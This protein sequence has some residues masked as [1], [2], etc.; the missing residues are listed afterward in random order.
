MPSI[1]LP[2]KLDQQTLEASLAKLEKTVKDNGKVLENSSLNFSD[3][4]QKGTNGFKNIVVGGAKAATIAFGTIAAT[5]A[6]VAAVS[7]GL[8]KTFD[9]VQNQVDTLGRAKLFGATIEQGEMLRKK[10]ED[11]KSS[12]E[13][14]ALA[15]TLVSGGFNKIEMGKFA[16]AINVISALSGQTKQSVEDMLKAGDLSEE[17]L[18]VLGKSRQELD[19]I[20][21][22]A[23]IA[24]G[25]RDL[26]SLEKAK[27]ILA[28]FGDDVNKLGKK[29]GDVGRSNP[30]AVLVKDIQSIWE[31]VVQSLKPAMDDLIKTINNNKQGLIDFFTAFSEL[32]IKAVAA[33]TPLVTKFNDFVNMSKQ[34]YASLTGTDKKISD[35]LEEQR[36]KQIADTKKA[37]ALVRQQE[38]EE[39]NNALALEKKKQADLSALREKAAN[40]RRAQA[41]KEALEE[42]KG[43]MAEARAMIRNF[44]MLMMEGIAAMGGPVSG[45]LGAQKDSFEK[46]KILTSLHKKVIDQHNSK[47]DEELKKLRETKKITDDQFKA[48]KLAQ[49]YSKAGEIDLREFI[50]NEKIVNIQLAAQGELLA[51][52]QKIAANRVESINHEKDVLAAITSLKAAIARDEGKTDFVSVRKLKVNKDTLKQYQQVSEIRQ[53]ILKTSL[54]QAQLDA[55]FELNQRLTAFDRASQSS[56]QATQQLGLQL[57]GLQGKE[58]ALETQRLAANQARLNLGNQIFD[59]EQK[60]ALL[61]DKMK[62]GQ[63]ETNLLLMNTEVKSLEA[64]NNQ[65]SKQLDLHKQ[66]FLQQKQNLTVG[67]AAMLQLMQMAS[68]ASQKIGQT[69]ATSVQNI[70]NTIGASISGLFEGLA[71]ADKDAGANFGKTLLSALGDI[72]TAFASTFMGIGVGKIA[73]GDVGG[74]A[75]LIAAS[76]AL[77]AVAGGLKGLAAGKTTSTSQSTTPSRTELPSTRPTKEQKSEPTYILV[78]N[79]IFGSE[80]EQ[81]RNLKQFVQRN[82]RITGQII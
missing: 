71:R 17:A 55:S 79:R 10:L 27:A 77:Y 38:K 78:S 42:Q 9:L 60:I 70:A 52:N 3:A 50:N 22:Q 29:L 82:Q 28:A 46:Y 36:L 68:D 32:S 12:T 7:V 35:I 72:A 80:E 54:E 30:F 73:L 18:R 53:K 11:V 6:G 61:R 2:I 24:A 81:A 19:V 8:S 23:S 57:V 62:S 33:L 51:A 13:A 26:S 14:L 40:A 1:V 16:D 31:K 74:G 43:R 76:V 66:I 56:L 39:K 44:D 5:I 59:N 34:A 65:L 45:A 4:L 37:W 64:T 25:G 75:A 67:G 47:S 20:L 63:S 48:I 41:Q 21:T 69:I 15:T 58:T 49:M